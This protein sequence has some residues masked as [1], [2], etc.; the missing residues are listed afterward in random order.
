MLSALIDAVDRDGFVTLPA[1]FSLD[2]TLTMIDALTDVIASASP[3]DPA[4]L[5]EPG[6][7]YG[8]RNILSLWPPATNL[9]RRE[10]LLLPLLAI[11][12]P[13]MGLV[14]GLYFDKPPG[15]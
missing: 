13:R 11:L 5:G 4:I 15:N 2:E 10:A 1:V 7:V 3:D 14:R 8:V 9:W 12:G 6:S